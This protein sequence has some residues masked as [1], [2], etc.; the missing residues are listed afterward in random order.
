MRELLSNKG[1]DM[2]TR[3]MNYGTSCEYSGAMNTLSTLLRIEHMQSNLD[4]RSEIYKN[5]N[6]IAKNLAEA[7]MKLI[8]ADE[9]KD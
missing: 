3:I 5:L 7:D 1:S 8:D 2:L 4:Q 9:E 6:D